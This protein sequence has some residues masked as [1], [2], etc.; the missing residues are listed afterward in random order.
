MCAQMCIFLHSK[1]FFGAF[2]IDIILIMVFQ[3]PLYLTV[4]NERGR[5][6]FDQNISYCFFHITSCLLHSWLRSR[7]WWCYQEIHILMNKIVREILRECTTKSSKQK[8]N[9]LKNKF[10]NALFTSLLWKFVNKMYFF[11]KKTPQKIAKMLIAF[12]QNRL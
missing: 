8:W 12:L 11:S 9:I 6:K 10:I 4:Y 2:Y 3:S 1:I 5:G 7:R